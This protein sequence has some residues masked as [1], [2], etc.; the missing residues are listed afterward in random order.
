M[1]GLGD[2]YS[3]AAMQSRAREQQM[4]WDVELANAFTLQGKVAVITGSGSGLDQ[5]CWQSWR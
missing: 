5:P 3:I 2:G 1:V 4:D